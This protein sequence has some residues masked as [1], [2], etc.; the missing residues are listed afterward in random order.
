MKRSSNFCLLRV[1]DFLS[2]SRTRDTISSKRSQSQITSLYFEL[3]RGKRNVVTRLSSDSSLSSPLLSPKTK[4]NSIGNAQTGYLYPDH[5]SADGCGK[6]TSACEQFFIEEG[7]FYECDHNLGKWR[8]HDDESCDNGNNGWQITGTPIKASYCDAWFEACKGPDTKMCMGALSEEGKPVYGYFSQPEC[9]SKEGTGGCRRIDE[10]Y[11]N[12]FHMCETMWS[13]SFKYETDTSADA[14]VM[15]F[16]EGATNPN[17]AMFTSKAYPPMC[18]GE[19]GFVDLTLAELEGCDADV[20]VNSNSYLGTAPEGTNVDLSSNTS[21]NATDET[22]RTNVDLSSNTS[23]PNAT[24]ETN[25]QGLSTPEGTNVDPSSK[26]VL[27]SSPT[28]P[29]LTEDSSNQRP[30]FSS[31]AVALSLVVAIVLFP[32]THDVWHSRNMF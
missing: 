24:D 28:T 14:Y 30:S 21:P 1:R 2:T 6:L 3:R 10:V 7:C 25:N 32:S 8:K 31:G 19:L 26:V 23:T 13:G 22:N 9:H 18:A 11:T 15:S 12:G 27:T 20:I 5:N 29:K 17:N 16:D 4:N